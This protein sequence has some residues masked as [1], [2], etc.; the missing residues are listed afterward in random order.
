MA[1]TKISGLAALTTVADGDLFP[2]VDVSDTSMGPTGTT[3]QVAAANLVPN[4]SITVSK[5]AAAVT[6]TELNDTYAGK[7]TTALTTADTGQTWGT[8]GDTAFLSII[9]DT[10]TTADD[11]KAYADIGLGSKVHRIG[12]RWDWTNGTVIEGTVGILIWATHISTPSSVPDSICHISISRTGLSYGV[13]DGGVYTDLLTHPFWRRL[14]L[15]T[16]YECEVFIDGDTATV[17]SPDGATLT[18]SDPLLVSL[19][20]SFAGFEC[21]N[22]PTADMLPRFHQVWADTRTV[23]PYNVAPLGGIMRAAADAATRAVIADDTN[24]GAGAYTHRFIDTA[25]AAGNTAFGANAHADLTTADGNTAIGLNAQANV[26]TGNNN[27]ALGSNTQATLT[28]AANNVAVGAAAQLALDSGTA[29]VAVGMQSQT[30]VTSG[31]SNTAV[32]HQS[33]DAV[34]TGGQN[35][36][37]GA[38]AQGALIDGS[39]NVAVGSGAQAAIT[40]GSNSTAVGTN[41]QAV[42]TSGANNTAVGVNAQNAVTSAG[43]NTA[44]GANA[45]LLLAT[46]SGANTAVGYAAQDALTTGHSNTAV[47]SDALGA[48]STGTTSTAVG[49]STLRSSTANNN[50]AIGA[51]AGYTPNGAANSTTTGARQTLVGV[52]TGLSSSS[53]INDITAVGYRA[54]CTGTGA[55]ALGSGAQAVHAGAVA[56]GMSAVTTAVDQVEIGARHFE[57]VEVTEPAA[58]ATNAARLYVKDNGSGKTQLCVRFATGAVAVLA[59]E[60]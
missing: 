33:Q 19:D 18:V 39:S 42:M 1:G 35:T 6:A 5:L 47:G 21:F 11:G 27:T 59:T 12:A 31:V 40:D 10:L 34:T 30:A 55:M 51:N 8:A 14:A 46:G 24:T 41:A 15:E 56:I 58:G 38:G 54:I 28:T 49:T 37:I 48:I 7:G 29:N 22:G 17:R 16:I 52:E 43:Q 50:T 45:Q 25:S 23:T 3:K 20:G 32:G 36:A 26:T 13:F 4:E 53:Q 57:L 60:P 2:I 9:D 44:V